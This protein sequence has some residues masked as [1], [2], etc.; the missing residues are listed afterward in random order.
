MIKRLTL[1]L[2]FIVVLMVS[3]QAADLQET[4][5]SLSGSS[6]E[7]YVNPLVSAFGSNMNGGWFHKAPQAKFLGWDLE[8]GMV[9]MASLFSDETKT[10]D[11]NA[12]FNFNRQQAE[13]LASSYTG[14]PFY[15]DLV[16]S[17][18]AANFN[19]RIKGPTIVGAKYDANAGM[20]ADGTNPT[21]LGVIFAGQA[22]SFDYNGTQQ[23]V[24][25][26]GKVFNLPFGGV[27]PDVPALPLAA[28]QLSIGTF[29]GTKLAL[30]FLPE[31]ELDPEIGKLQYLGFGIQ[32][33]PAYW[34]PVKIPVDLGL[35]FFTQDLKVGDI[36]E[37]KATTFGLNV[38]KTWGMKLLNVTP[39]AGISAE[40][41]QM[42][43]HYD[44]PTNTTDPN[45]P[46]NVNIAFDVDG[47]NSSRITL[48][49][50][51]RMAL[52][53]LNFDY[54]IA[55]YSSATMGLMLNFSW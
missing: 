55:K 43:F 27:L 3:L 32:H 26:P 42:K 53:N 11:S 36:I 22:F 31:V 21:G 35:S 20:G 7:A 10:F 29:A 16:N 30:R 14:M 4:L 44:Y 37:T 6:A 49:T 17:I 24:T 41:S 8:L 2:S 47:E 28:P 50:S 23:P 48:G 12:Y 33:N 39:Y 40:S 15:N 52:F 13:T 5:E 38:S 46:A 18:M 19:I 25:L 51:F 9:A 54:N 45:M 34:L 1:L